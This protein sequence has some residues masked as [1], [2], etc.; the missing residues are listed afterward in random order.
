M[1][2]LSMPRKCAK[3]DKIDKM[4]ATLSGQS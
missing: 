4:I 2:K 3:I 1:S